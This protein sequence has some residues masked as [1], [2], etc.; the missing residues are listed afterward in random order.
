MKKLGFSIA[1]MM[2]MI[3]IIAIGRASDPD[4][5][6]EAQKISVVSSPE[7]TTLTSHW[8]SNFSEQHPGAEIQVIEASPKIKRLEN[9]EGNVLITSKT[10]DMSRDK[11]PW[12]VTIGRRVVV[13]VINSRNPLCDDIAK[14]GIS[15]KEL[16][17]AVTGQTTSWGAIL[18]SSN[19]DENI[20]YLQCNDPT[21][22]EQVSNFLGVKETQPFK[23]YDNPEELVAAIQ[24][25]PR[26]IG[27]CSLKH[28]I[29]NDKSKLKPG[30]AILPIDRNESGKIE[31]ME[32]I[33]DDLNTFMRGV[34]IGKFPHSL[35]QNIHLMA[36]EKPSDSTTKA[37]INFIL[38]AGQDDLNTFGF[39]NLAYSE[40][41][42][43]M[44]RLSE[45][46]IGITTA[47]SD[48]FSLVKIILIILVILFVVGYIVSRYFGF[49]HTEKSKKAIENR[50]ENQIPDPHIIKAPEGL[51]FDKSHT[52]TFMEK[53]GLVRMGLD[54]FMQHITG[55]LTR[56]NMKKPGEPVKKGEPAITL[57]QEGKQLTIKA[58]ITGTIQEHNKTLLHGVEK[59][60]T[61]P[62]T[63]GWIYL[64]E[65]DNW[66]S[67]IQFLKMANNYREW[68]KNEF[69]RLKDF[70]SY[71]ISID[72]NVT[73]RVVMQ[74]GGALKDHL[75]E[76]LGPVLW[77]EFQR[78]FIDT[79]K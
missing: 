68:L 32:D 39:S 18:D 79:P 5:K 29:S 41:Q 67:E 17:M 8:A 40:R 73:E 52:W 36:E 33:C 46:E 70:V 71:T 19:S 56:V 51:Y 10:R 1:L 75:L 38:T 69:A 55:P 21:I 64:I 47:P 60:N 37:F 27:F 20:H 72:K 11:Q 54:D 59:I 23:N 16:Q 28:L 26:A 14:C 58:P 35:C 76:E 6:K 31:H 57:I 24:N 61:Q 7:L 45:Q 25:D 42:A 49:F 2:F 34:W 48:S 62:Y 66:Q 63:E 53:N 12:E 50:A 77:E 4:Q 9:L 13:P 78:K 3:S 15:S 74:D 44:N 22:N 65:P 30:I 43:M